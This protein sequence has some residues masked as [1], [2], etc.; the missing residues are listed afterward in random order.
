MRKKQL[1]KRC[2]CRSRL[3]KAQ[4][5]AAAAG[6]HDKMITVELGALFKGEEG[7]IDGDEVEE[8][9]NFL[10]S[11]IKTVCGTSGTLNCWRK[12]APPPSSRRM[13]QGGGRGD[14]SCGGGH[15]LCDRSSATST[16]VRKMHILQHLIRKK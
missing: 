2:F 11:P 12:Y 6:D 14:E 15:Q 3:A 1:R 10:L 5:E 4:T 16:L 7:C 8:V 13:W 9:R